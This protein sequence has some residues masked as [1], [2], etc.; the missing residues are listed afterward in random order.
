MIPRPHLELLAAASTDAPD[1]S[2]IDLN[3]QPARGTEHPSAVTDRER[4]VFGG[5][6]L[7]LA[8]GNSLGSAESANWTRTNSPDVPDFTDT[9]CPAYLLIWNADAAV[10]GCHSDACR[11]DGAAL[12]GLAGAAVGERPRVRSDRAG[13][14]RAFWR[15]V[16]E[17]DEG[18]PGAPPADSRAPSG[19]AIEVIVCAR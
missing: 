12:T 10:R 1:S 13:H 19:V 18:G 16:N 6:S 5:P 15:C 7:Q 3:S 17:E 9:E 8:K 2:A 14:R 11:N 4:D